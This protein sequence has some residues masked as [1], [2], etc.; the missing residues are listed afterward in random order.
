MKYKDLSG[1][2]N[3][4]IKY[5]KILDLIEDRCN[6]IEIVLISNRKNNELAELF[7]KDIILKENVSKWWGTEST[8]K[9]IL[10]R[11]KSSKE[12][13]AK[14]RQYETLCKYYES[15]NGDYSKTTSFGQ[16]DIAFFDDKEEPL[17][18]TT[19]HEGYIYL[20][21]DIKSN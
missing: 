18:F 13:F 6:Y 2:I 17:L 4:S 19:T 21:E 16:D 8:G 20:R 9:H 1:K 14:L 15:D 12:L 3:D 5:N 10:Y 7:K 11:I